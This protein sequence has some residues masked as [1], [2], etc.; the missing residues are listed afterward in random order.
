MHRATAI[1]KR[2]CPARAETDAD[3]QSALDRHHAPNRNA[4]FSSER[5]IIASHVHEQWRRIN[6]TVDPIQNS[7]VTGYSCSH[8]F[9]SDVALNHANRKIAQLPANSNDQAG[10]NKLPH[11]KEWKREVKKPRQNHSDAQRSERAFPCLVR[12]DF[13]AQ[14]MAAENFSESKCRDVSQS[15][16]ENNVANKAVSV[17]SVSDKSEVTEHPADVNKTN[18]GERYALQLAASAIA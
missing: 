5:I 2:A 11:T 1:R 16:R 13:A 4:T 3:D 9:G 17:A 12:T 10:Q 18:N 6:Q 8:V 7:A 14:R 15:R